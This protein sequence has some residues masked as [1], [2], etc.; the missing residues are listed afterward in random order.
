M[1]TMQTA[2]DFRQESRSLAAAIEPL[3][4][5]GYLRP[6]LFKGWT[7]N[8]ILGH[9]HMF[10]V[11]AERT[12]LSAGEFEAFFAPIRQALEQGQTLLQ[13]QEPWLQDL[14]GRALFE[15]W[16]EGAERLADA[17]TRADPKQ[18]VKWAGPDMSALSSI[19]ARQMETWAH[20]Q[21]V[22]D[23]LGLERKETDRIKNI[24]HL[25]VTTFGWTFINRQQAVPEPAPHVVLTAP[26]GAVW[27]WN[28]EQAGNAVVG[29]AV[30]FARVV[31]QVRH[32]ND[33]EI[34]TRGDIAQRWMAW[35]QCFAGPPVE[36][37]PPGSRHMVTTP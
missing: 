18:R 28:K 31:T 22:F 16:A 8:D 19:T 12:L 5:N 2:E 11:A 6:T 34:Q 1:T 32:V 36:P 25:G 7:V 13:S 37:P 10:N 9:L 17:Y 4:A 27:T 21:A 23:L 30:E 33:T 35:A 14:S 29:S 24:A 26:S 15:A 3:G 20:G